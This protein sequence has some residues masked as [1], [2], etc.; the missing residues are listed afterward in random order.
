MFTIT[1]VGPLILSRDPINALE[2]V[3]KQYADQ[4]LTNLDASKFISGTLQVSRLP[5]FTGDV[6]SSAGTNNFTLVNTGV[7]AGTYT[8]VNVNAKGLVT[9]GSSLTESDIPNLSWN[10]IT[11]D[12]PTT[13]SGYGITDALLKSG[14]TVT[15]SLT[16]HSDPTNVNHLA[17]K[18]YVDNKVNDNLIIKTGDIIIKPTTNTPPGFLR[19]NGA[20][21][22]KTTYSALYA[23]IGD[24]FSHKVQP[25]SGQPWRQQY[26]INDTQNGDITG[27][28]TGPSLPGPLAYS[29][30]IV[31]KNRVYLLGGNNGSSVTNTVYTA[32]INSDGTLGT[33]STSNPT[34]FSSTG[35]Q[36]VVVRNRV[37][38]LGLANAVYSSFINHDDTL[39]EWVASSAPAVIVN[40]SQAIITKGR[41]Y[42]LGGRT[43]NSN[44]TNIV[45]TAPINN[46]GTLGQWSISDSL[47]N[48]LGHSQAIVTKNR[49]YLL[50][51]YDG[52]SHTDVVYTAPINSDGTLGTWT[53]GTPLPTVITDHIAVATKYRVYILG[54]LGLQTDLDTVYTAPIN[55]DGTLG[56]WTSGTPLNTKIY[57]HQAI[58]TKNRIYLLAGRNASGVNDTVLTASFSG[59]LNDYSQYYD[60][61]VTWTDPN[62]FRLPNL[63]SNDLPGTY[64]Y[65][66]Y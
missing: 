46:D 66:K 47:P 18:Q 63:T 55:S 21:V 9:S 38:L 44:I 3:T 29:Q 14:G 32:P 54:G 16:L 58:I 36:A 25:G 1:S 40:N 19:C 10:K 60:G 24:Q 15:G 62:N 49:V 61:S 53:T 27:W 4:K 13:I 59:G 33:W 28:T 23:I 65:I 22:S 12:K 37:Y 41:I 30:A 52:N 42:L 35:S 43:V 50:G 20:Q 51:G 5:A 31:T 45:Q 34:P 48:P 64:S 17:T 39:S 7:T 6:V 57:G 8:K 56:T 26:Y 11:S 2:A